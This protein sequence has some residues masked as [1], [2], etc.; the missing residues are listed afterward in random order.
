[1]IKYIY[2]DGGRKEAGFRGGASDCLTRAIAI[3]TKR[4]YGEVYKEVGDYFD[5]AGWSRSGAR[6]VFTRRSG[7]TRNAYTVQ[8]RLIHEFGFIKV[9]CKLPDGRWPTLTQ[10]WNEF[11]DHMFTTTKHIAAIADG[12]LRDC[13]DI[14]T[15]EWNDEERERK[16]ASVYVLAGD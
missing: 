14:R 12:A 3:L 10:A 5:E 2:D 7:R 8:K 15:Y 16:A 4:P 6:G 13:T 1:M 9:P 11:G